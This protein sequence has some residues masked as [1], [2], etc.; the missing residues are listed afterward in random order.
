MLN[1]WHLKLYSNKTLQ[2]S[3]AKTYFIGFKCQ[4]IAID[5]AIENVNNRIDF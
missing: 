3:Q 4:C 1:Q 2:G 5:K